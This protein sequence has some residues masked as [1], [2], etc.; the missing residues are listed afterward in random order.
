M[1][2]QA[3]GP[4]PL[5]LKKGWLNDQ[6]AKAWQDVQRWPAWMRRAAGLV[7]D[8]SNKTL[9]DVRGSRG[10]HMRRDLVYSTEDELGYINDLLWRDPKG[11]RQYCRLILRGR[12][13][14]STVDVAAV[15][16]RARE[17][18]EAPIATGHAGR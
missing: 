6:Y 12:R 13:W 4:A 14:D 15:E 1:R 11:A 16:R 9:S 8:R 7:R 5:S 18:L 17:I 2:D 10:N 3:C